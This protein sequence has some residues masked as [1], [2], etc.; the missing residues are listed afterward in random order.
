MR[1]TIY[2][3]ALM[4]IVCFIAYTNASCDMANH[5]C[6]YD[7]NCQYDTNGYNKCTCTTTFGYT[8]CTCQPGGTP[9]SGPDCPKLGAH[10]TTNASCADATDGAL[11]CNLGATNYNIGCP[12]RF[13][14]SSACSL[15]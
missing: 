6:A 8:I 5:I 13:V 3:F 10:C 15:V 9:Y 1:T 14:G 11:W 7:S 4:A 12:N 2:I